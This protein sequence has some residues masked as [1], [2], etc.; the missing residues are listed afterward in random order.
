[1]ELWLRTKAWVGNA[2]VDPAV[3]ATAGVAEAQAQARSPLA[4]ALAA[5]RR[6]AGPSPASKP[7]P[8]SMSDARRMMPPP[9]PRFAASSLVCGLV[10]TA[11]HVAASEAT[12]KGPLASGLAGLVDYGDDDEDE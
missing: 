8:L 1:M 6:G 5:R 3:A 10:D 12:V 2:A 11:P 7:A 9:P 4:R